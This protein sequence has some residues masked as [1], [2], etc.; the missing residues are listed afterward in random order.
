M[1][2]RSAPW[3]E[4]TF[5]VMLRMPRS[6]FQNLRR[7][8]ISMMTR[9]MMTMT[10]AALIKA[11]LNQVKR[12]SVPSSPSHVVVPPSPPPRRRAKEVRWSVVPQSWSSSSSTQGSSQTNSCFPSSK[13]PRQMSSAWSSAGVAIQISKSLPKERTTSPFRSKIVM[14]KMGE[15]GWSP[16]SLG[17]STGLTT[18]VPPSGNTSPG[19]V[20]TPMRSSLSLMTSTMTSLLSSCSCSTG[21]GR[22]G[23]EGRG[24]ST[25][26]RGA[27]P[28]TTGVLVAEGWT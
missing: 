24:C 4:V 26:G 17:L 25:E 23:P 6:F 19:T 2:A 7:T 13:N 27:W 11:M 16:V 10:R 12:R 14:S 18:I 9:A 3:R 15:I 21:N 22:G 20:M 8:L 28:T 5:L 1:G